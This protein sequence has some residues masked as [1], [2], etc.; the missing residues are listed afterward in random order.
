MASRKTTDM[1]TAPNLAAKLRRCAMGYVFVASLSFSPVAHA[2]EASDAQIE[3]MTDAIVGIL[4]FGA[5]M[6]KSAAEDP[7]WPVKG[8]SDRFASN[9]VACL[10]DQLSTVGYRRSKRADVVAYAAA[11]SDR[12]ERDLKSLESVAP[13]F[14]AIRQKKDEDAFEALMSTMSA[15]RMLAFVGFIEDEEHAPLRKLVGLGEKGFGQGGSTPF[16]AGVS[17]GERNAEGLM[18]KAMEACSIPFSRLF[19]RFVPAPPLDERFSL[20]E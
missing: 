6:D 2:G 1:M 3:R 14:A 5:Q 20:R 15:D 9:E 4:D 10:R 12:F 13:V 17:A 8:M 18:L 11:N 7:L 19:S 16:E